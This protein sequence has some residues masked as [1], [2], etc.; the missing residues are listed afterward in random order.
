M[1]LASFFLICWPLA[2]MR[3]PAGA[4]LNIRLTDKVASETTAA[5]AVIHAVLISPVAVD[6]QIA[7]PLGA[8]LTGEVTKVNATAEKV[9]ATMLLTFNQIGTGAYETKLAAVVSGL[10]NARESVDADGTIKG[11]DGT[12]T[13]S[14]RIDQGVE[15][16]KASDRFAALAG[17]IETTKQ[18]LKIQPANANIDYDA[19]VEMTLRLTAPLDWRGPVAGPEAKLVPLPNQDALEDLVAREPYRTVAASPPRPSD[20]TNI[21]L[22]ATEAEIQA[23]FAKAGWSTAAR[24]TTQSKL[25][26]ARALIEDRG[27]REGPMSVLLLDG[28]PPAF[29]FQKGNNTYAARHHLRIFRRPQIFDGKPVWVISSTHD[30]GIDFSE[31]DRTFIHR[32]DS[33][34]DHERA[35]VVND[36]LYAGAVRSLALVER[37][38][39]ENLMN[40]TGDAIHTDGRMAVLLLQ[41][42]IR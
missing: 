32:I 7:L 36:L 10:D 15:K 4:E 17:L 25:E 37:D 41:Q 21:M 6:G 9:L 14:S 39:P 22:I 30:T 34:I 23:A 28:Q 24:L 11:I 38:L 29:A 12:E 20:V 33:D 40:A 2:A 16:L 27:Y 19:G 13:F 5:H 3:I 1:K 42:P 31:R 35:K 8:Q 18:A 26:T